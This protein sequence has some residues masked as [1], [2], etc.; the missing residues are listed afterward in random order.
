M[1]RKP[2][3]N[4]HPGQH[5]RPRWRQSRAKTHPDRD[6]APRPGARW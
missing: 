6:R 3:A 4:G 5:P 1:S 2:A